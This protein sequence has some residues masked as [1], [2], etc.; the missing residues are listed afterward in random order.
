MIAHA[1]DRIHACH[2]PED[3]HTLGQRSRSGSMAA[4]KDDHVQRPTAAVANWYSGRAKATISTPRPRISPEPRVP[5]K[6][7]FVWFVPSAALARSQV[8]DRSAC[9]VA[10]ATGDQLEHFG[11]FPRPWAADTASTAEAADTT[12][13]TPGTATLGQR[14]CGR[15]EADCGSPPARGHVRPLTAAANTG[16]A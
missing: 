15:P 2:H 8:A 1:C 3:A 5:A 12:G 7:R 16:E 6:S 4:A 13:R 11:P 9:A 10:R 14:N